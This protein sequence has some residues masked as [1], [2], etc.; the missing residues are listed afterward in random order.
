MVCSIEIYIVSIAT[1]G[2]FNRIK[3]QLWCHSIVQTVDSDYIMVLVHVLIYLAVDTNESD[4][5]GFL[6]ATEYCL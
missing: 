2:T 4:R 3:I 1:S 5:D 6:S